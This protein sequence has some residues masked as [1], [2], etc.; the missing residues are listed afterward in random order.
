VGV[1]LQ[2][3]KRIERARA[4]EKGE[5]ERERERE[6]ERKRDVAVGLEE[7]DTPAHCQ[8]LPART[9]GLKMLAYAALANIHTYI[10]LPP[11]YICI[12]IYVYIYIV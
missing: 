7:A 10:S 11:V 5:S 8:S 4:R 9:S 3:E 2:R 1:H 6:R 12:Y